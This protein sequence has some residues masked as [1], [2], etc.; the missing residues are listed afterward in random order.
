MSNSWIASDLCQAFLRSSKKHTE[1]ELSQ[2][3][4]ETTGKYEINLEDFQNILS[5]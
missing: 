5:Q 3:I 2:M 1:E 4:Y